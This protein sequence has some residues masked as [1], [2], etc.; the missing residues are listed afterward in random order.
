MSVLKGLSSVGRGERER[1]TER[2]ME[3][4]HVLVLSSGETSRSG[5]KEARGIAA[6]LCFTYVH[7]KLVT[8]IF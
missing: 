3:N 5:T 4:F 2:L 1:K 8:S 6:E 7:Y